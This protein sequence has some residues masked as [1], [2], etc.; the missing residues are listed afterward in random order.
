MADENFD[1]PATPVP[2][3]EALRHL[4]RKEM[5]FQ[6]VHLRGLLDEN[7]KLVKNQSIYFFVDTIITSQEILQAFDKAGIDID[8]IVCIQR[9]MSNRSW[10]VTYDSPVT[11][12]AALEVASVEI[13]GHTIFLGECEHRLVLV[14][15]YEAPAELSD[16]ALIGRM[17]HY[18]RVL[19][20]RRDK[21]ADAIDNGVRTARMELHRHIPSIINLAGEVM[22]VWYPSQPKMYRNCGAKD[23]IVKDC[24]S[25]R[26]MNCEQPGH[27]SEDCG[28]PLLC[29]VCKAPNHIM[30]NCPYV[31]YS[32][33]VATNV[34]P[35]RRAP[36]NENDVGDRAKT[37]R[38]GLKA[39]RE[40]RKAEYREEQQ[41][42]QRQQ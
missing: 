3:P 42:Q 23:H 13:G 31:L 19:S 30:N 29:G 5:Q 20:F 7:P 14:K 32:A 27:R 25:V 38:E 36:E 4:A 18:G 15:I 10:V 22:R 40:R 34:N 12:E 17:S 8:E 39:E 6:K 21:I 26:C 16:T 37:E 2:V 11:K 1:T 35:V 28:E 33:N 24:N 41:R 9:K